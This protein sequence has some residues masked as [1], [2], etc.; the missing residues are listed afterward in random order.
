MPLYVCASCRKDLRCERNSVRLRYGD[1]SHVYEG[2]RYICP[3]CGTMTVAGI[4][5]E[6]YHDPTPP[7]QWKDLDI[8]MRDDEE[9]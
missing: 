9:R 1:G 5:K 8:D 2:D 6:A 7:E 3:D 4:A